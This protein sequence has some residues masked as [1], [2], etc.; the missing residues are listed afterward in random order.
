[1]WHPFFTNA[2]KSNI[3]IMKNL[4]N[5]YTNLSFLSIAA[6]ILVAGMSSCSSE[7]EKNQLNLFQ[8]EKTSLSESINSS[9]KDIDEAIAD[10]EDKLNINEGPVERSIEKTLADLEDQ[11]EKLQNDLRK[12]ENSL[13]ED[14]KSI[15]AKTEKSLSSV[16]QN[17]GKIKKDIS[18]KVEQITDK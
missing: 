9:L 15:K 13:E 16:E 2:I 18:E 4:I 14:W 5:K 1:M 12:V 6:F 7:K 17:L 11:K 10:V 8:Q 3:R